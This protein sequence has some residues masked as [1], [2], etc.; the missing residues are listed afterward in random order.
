MISSCANCRF[1]HAD[2][3][4][5]FPDVDGMCRRYAPQG[6]V[7]GSHSNGWQIFPP[8]L[9]HQWCGDYAPAP[10]ATNRQRVAA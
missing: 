1:F 3:S 2:T 7:I 5:A 8:M 4:K 10:V 9:A 6:A